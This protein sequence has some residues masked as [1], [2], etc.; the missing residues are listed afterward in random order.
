MPWIVPPKS[1]GE[2]KDADGVKGKSSGEPGEVITCC[3]E[4]VNCNVVRQRLSAALGWDDVFVA[5]NLP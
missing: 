1:H 4:R 3:A 2:R 5:G